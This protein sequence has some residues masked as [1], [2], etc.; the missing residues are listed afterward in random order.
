MCFTKIP[1]LLQQLSLKESLL[2]FGSSCLKFELIYSCLAFCKNLLFLIIEH[3][4]EDEKYVELDYELLAVL[5]NV[6]EGAARSSF[7][8]QARSWVRRMASGGW[9]LFAQFIEWSSYSAATHTCDTQ[10][11]EGRRRIWG[12]AHGMVIES[13]REGAPVWGK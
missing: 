1:V 10:K 7:S 13:C 3:H 8:N 2:F 6:T 4:A 11:M 5:A 12:E 9:W